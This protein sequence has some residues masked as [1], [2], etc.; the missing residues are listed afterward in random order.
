M[1]ET[2]RTHPEL[3]PRR[4]ACPLADHPDN[5]GRQLAAALRTEH[6]NAVGALLRALQQ[7]HGVRLQRVRRGLAALP[8]PNPKRAIARGVEIE[9]RPAQI[10]RLADPQP[11]P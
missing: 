1:P 5:V 4:S 9:V 10:D 11:M 6:V 3:E 7:A 2:M 8:P